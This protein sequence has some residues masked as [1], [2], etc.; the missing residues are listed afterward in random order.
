MF[1]TGNEER[2]TTNHNQVWLSSRKTVLRSTQHLK[3]D[4]PSVP[5][6]IHH[7]IMKE[8]SDVL[9][10]PMVMLFDLFLPHPSV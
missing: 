6:D 2:S 10:G 9:A 7:G 8:L 5:D 3:P 4:K 1:S